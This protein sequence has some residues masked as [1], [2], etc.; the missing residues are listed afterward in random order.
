MYKDYLPKAQ[1]AIFLAGQQ[2]ENKQEAGTAQST[3]IERESLVFNYQRWGTYNDFPQRWNKAIAANGTLAQGLRQCSNGIISGGLVYGTLK[4]DEE[5]GKEKL[6]PA[7]DEKV[8]EWFKRTNIKKFLRELSNEYW[9]FWNVFVEAVMTKDRSEIYSLNVQESTFCR[10]ATQNERT[11]QIDKVYI[12]ANWHLGDTE[13]S[14][15]TIPVPCLDPYNEPAEQIRK[16]KKYK[17]ILPVQ[18]TDSGRIGYQYAPHHTLLESKW[19]ELSNE[20]GSYKLSLI[21]N[22]IAVKYI[23]YVH[24]KYW[25]VKYPEWDEMLDADKINKINTLKTEIE[26]KLS[27][28]KNAGKSIHI[29]MSF[30]EHT[31]KLEKLI[32]IEAVKDEIKEGTWIAESLESVSH[33]LFAL[34]LDSWVGN[35]PGKSSFSGSDKREAYNIFITNSK[36][37][38]DIM[39][40]PLELVRDYN[41]WNP[42]YKFWF[43]NYYLQTLDAVNPSA[44]NTSE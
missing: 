2:F 4:I 22:Q 40:E 15:Y 7:K 27:G 20:I 18:G 43:R 25:Y 24:E 21:R 17:Y 14:F 39:L 32:E 35:T 33:I 5:T 6:I 3:P 37:D 10:F 19:L 36:P 29:P 1:A 44:R 26:E 42:E 30:D 12:S 11:G 9:R 34:G 13:N 23:I 38:Q 28:T 8:E 16:G 41:G 31:Q